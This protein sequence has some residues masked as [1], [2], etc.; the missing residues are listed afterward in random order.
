MDFVIENIRLRELV[1]V[2]RENRAF[3]TDLPAFIH[4]KDDTI[5]LTTVATYLKRKSDAT[6][7]DGLGQPYSNAKARWFF[8]GSF[9]MRPYSG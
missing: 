8:R 4:E 3:F 5:A 9:V 7:L 2:I 1:A 6:L